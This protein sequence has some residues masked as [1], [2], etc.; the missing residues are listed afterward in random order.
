MLTS[1]PSS[2]SIK[3]IWCYSEEVEEKRNNIVQKEES[4]GEVP[5]HVRNS[6]GMFTETKK[7]LYLLVHITGLIKI[8]TF[9]R[10]ELRN[11]NQSVQDR[12]EFFMGFSLH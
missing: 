3:N 4:R 7:L 2:A 8:Y 12:M 5:F 6:T 10:N 1:P 11:L 9:I